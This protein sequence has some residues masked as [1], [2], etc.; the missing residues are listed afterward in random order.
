MGREML[1]GD[2]GPSA[3]RRY[4]ELVDRELQRL[5]AAAGGDHLP[6]VLVA[7]GGYGRHHLCPYSDIDLLV[8]F[9][10]AVDTRGERFLRDLL[11][12]LWDS[13]LVVGHQVRESGELA[14]LD[15][16]NAEFLLAAIDA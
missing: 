1:A 4:S 2:A 15:E 16:D 8:L 10:G 12:P 7:L 9:G 13:G 3:L 5:Y 6:V 14:A 11:H